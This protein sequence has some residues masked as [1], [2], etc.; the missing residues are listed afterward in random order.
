MESAIGEIRTK[1]NSLIGIDVNVL[2]GMPTGERSLSDLG[3]GGSYLGYTVSKWVDVTYLESAINT[4]RSTIR[5]LIIFL[6]VLFNL[7]QTLMLFGAS[8]MSMIGS[9]TGSNKANST[10]VGKGDSE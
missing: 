7:N 5:G 10:K 1:F 6:L 8:P 9:I 2:S 4:F 3:N